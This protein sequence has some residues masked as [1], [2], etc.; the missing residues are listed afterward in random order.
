[1]RVQRAGIV[2]RTPDGCP[3]RVVIAMSKI[4][5]DGVRAL[6]AW[7]PTGHHAVTPLGGGLI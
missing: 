1:M 2:R 6:F 5:P 4:T 3:A 7:S